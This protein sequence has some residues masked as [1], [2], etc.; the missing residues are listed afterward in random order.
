[1][2]HRYLRSRFSLPSEFIGLL[3]LILDFELSQVSQVIGVIET[4][5]LSV[6]EEKEEEEEDD[7]I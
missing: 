7:Y 6:N 1:M 3:V 5:R 2:W 4:L